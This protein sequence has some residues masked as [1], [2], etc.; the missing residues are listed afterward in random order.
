M[1]GFPSQR[2]SHSRC[3]DSRI[4]LALA[5]PNASQDNRVSI[6]K[7]LT[8]R[9]SINYFFYLVRF[10]RVTRF[11]NTKI[12]EREANRLVFLKWKNDAFV[13]CKV[14]RKIG[15]KIVLMVRVGEGRNM[16]WRGEG[17][18]PEVGRVNPGPFELPRSIARIS[19]QQRASNRFVIVR[20][21]SISI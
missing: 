20:I 10:I 21:V 19:L 5:R 7:R 14:V 16:G 9:F 12:N 2:A 15:R 18:T 6:S 11:I 8:R 1:V 13:R 3:C 17:R 4:A